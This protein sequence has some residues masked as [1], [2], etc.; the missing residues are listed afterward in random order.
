MA[1]AT[2]NST[3]AFRS[4]EAPIVN[5][6]VALLGLL[7]LI[8][9]LDRETQIRNGFHDKL[10]LAWRY[11]WVDLAGEDDWVAFVVLTNVWATAVYWFVGG[12]FS[13]LDF[14][15][16]EFTRKYKMQP[17]VNQPVSAKKYLKTAAQVLFNQ[18]VVGP[19]L[20]VA[21][22]P[23]L[24]WRGID[25]TANNIPGIAVFL[26][27]FIGYAICEEIGFYYAH[28]LFHEVK[29]LYIHIHKQHH[30]WVAPI[31]IAAR[32][33]HPIEDILAN[34]GPV[35]SGP[36]ICGS[37]LVFW[38]IWLL[39][40]LASTVISHSGYHF[41]LLPSTEF[42]DFHHLRFD[43]NYGMLGVLDALHNTDAKFRSSVCSL[44]HH[45]LTSLKSAREEFPDDVVA[46]ANE[47]KTD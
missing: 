17:N 22:M 11:V 2:K 23:L 28:R 46:N 20:A 39:I 10:T 43:V 1:G 47:A 41:P 27:H 45:M 12:I 19:L 6:L 37:P 13:I 16:F 36:L 42:H 15:N 38:W 18:F 30:E 40:G 4:R 21:V 14:G 24:R 5:F 7:L 33:A 9:F 31:S 25:F 34:V 3:G 44:R 29:P 26:R 35:M 8:A 32:Y